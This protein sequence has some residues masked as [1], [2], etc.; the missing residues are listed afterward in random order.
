MKL[1]EAMER[2][3]TS[4]LTT[5]RMT[6]DSEIAWR[7][8]VRA[9]VISQPDL[10]RHLAVHTG[11]LSQAIHERDAREVAGQVL[12]LVLAPLGHVLGRTPW[13]NPGRATV[14]K[15]AKAPLPADVARLYAEAGI[16]V[17]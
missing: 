14:S 2:A 15:F 7:A 9:H 8:L 4:E 13:G 5:A 12:R 17:T 10:P 3:V 11:M 6:D 1:P 16:K